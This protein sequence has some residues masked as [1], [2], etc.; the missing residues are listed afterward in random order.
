MFGRCCGSGR[1]RGD[2][3]GGRCNGYVGGK[4]APEHYQDGLFGTPT[5]TTWTRGQPAEVYWASA[6]RHKGGY[7]YR[8][9]KVNE[10]KFWEVT[11]E[12]FQQ[13]HLNFHG[14]LT[15]TYS[16][17]KLSGYLGTQHWIYPYFKNNIR[18]YSPDNWIARTLVTTTKGTTPKGSMWAKID[19][20][21]PPKT[22]TVKGYMFKDVVEVPENLEPGDYVLSYRWDCERTPQVWN[23]CANINIVQ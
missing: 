21:E 20:P 12:C 7:A 9:C 3:Q 13:G 1:P 15:L 19:L 10:G 22:S 2:S 5:V 6:A 11:E 17:F 16:S 14:T 8:L 4:P 18:D 23:S